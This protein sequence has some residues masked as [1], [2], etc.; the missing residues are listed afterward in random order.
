MKN[1]LNQEINKPINKRSVFTPPSIV[2][3]RVKLE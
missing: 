2:S 1:E 3:V